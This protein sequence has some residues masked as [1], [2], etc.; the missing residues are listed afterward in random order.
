MPH[1]LN[2]PYSSPLS[3]QTQE[4]LPQLM[5]QEKYLLSTDGDHGEADPT[6]EVETKPS[7]GQALVGSRDNSL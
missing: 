4:L 6:V 3:P 7:A 5:I 2:P 1:T